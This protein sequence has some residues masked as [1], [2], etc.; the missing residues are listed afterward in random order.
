MESENLSV[1]IFSMILYKMGLSTLQKETFICYY[2]RKEVIDF[3]C[4]HRNHIFSKK[5]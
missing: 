2:E 4:Y 1:Y 5:S 3:R